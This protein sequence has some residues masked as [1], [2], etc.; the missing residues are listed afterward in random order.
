MTATTDFKM[1]FGL[2]GTLMEKLVVKK[3]FDGVLTE[4]YNRFKD[5]SE[6]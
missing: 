5:Y 2:L 6:K 3:K 4:L 1:K